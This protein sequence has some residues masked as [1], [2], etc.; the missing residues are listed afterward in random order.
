MK[1]NLLLVLLLINLSFPQS[2]FKFAWLTDIHIGDANATEDLSRSVDDINSIDDISFTIISGDVTAIGSLNQ[3]VTAKQILGKLNKAYYIIPG[4][5]DTKWSESGCTDFIKL[6]QNDR[7]VF[8]FDKFLFVGLHQGPQMR[9]ADG[10]FA[11]EDLQWFDSTI[12]AMKN[13]NQ[14]IIF[15]THYP[16]NDEIANYKEMLSRLKNL[17]IQV[18]LFGH[19]H[20]NKVYNF[21]GI[22]G[23]MSRSNLRAKDEIGGYTIVEIKNDSLFFTKRTPIKEIKNIWHSI[24]LENHSIQKTPIEKFQISDLNFKFCKETNITIGSNPVVDN[25]KIFYTD[26]S[27]KI[28]CL[29]SNDGNTIWH[30]KTNAPVYSTPEVEDTFVVFGSAD[31]LIYCLNSET[32]KLIWKFK[33]NAAVLGS[34]VIKD[35]IVFIGGSDRIFRALNLQTGK[36]IWQFNGLNGFVESKPVLYDDKILFGAWD[37]HFY[38]L[39]SQTGKLIW[40]WKGDKNGELY[41]PAA[42]WA[43]AS[44]GIV[45][46][47]APDR[48]LTALEIETGNQLWRSGKYKVRETIGMSEAGDKL[49]IRTMNDTILALPVSDKLEEPLWIAN[50]GFGY[51]ISSAQIVE[52]DGM[53]FYPTK[54]GEVFALDSETGD[55]IFNKKLSDGYVNT[56]YPISNNEIILTG[57]DG[58]VKRYKFVTQE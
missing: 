47:A 54:T 38:C 32:G 3:F 58:C 34:A 51:D 30:Y 29:D 27:G 23:I 52:K 22:N 25:E 6:W 48:R 24:K 57:F 13:P 11:P 4:N 40:K 44:K 19:G 50:C 36:L 56:I 42:C 20:Q 31:S 39:D 49:F 12:T 15:V 28:N 41:S 8:E 16:L 7:F 37:E 14:P 46:F 17:N 43:V 9:M 18:V 53:I 21:D 10:Y 33:T 35:D 2:N 45:F 55:I 1:K 26:A 5:H